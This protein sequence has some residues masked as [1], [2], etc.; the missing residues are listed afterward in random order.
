MAHFKE[1]RILSGSIMTGVKRWGIPLYSES[2]TLFGSA[3]ISLTSSGLARKRIVAINEFKRTDFPDPVVPAIKTWGILEISATIM[4]P[5]TSKP[6]PTAIFCLFVRNT[7]LESVLFKVTISGEILGISI[8]TKDFP[9]IGASIL[10]LP[11][12]VA[13]ARAR[14]F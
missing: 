2:S 1:D 3:R 9:G 13:N 11:V 14:S 10:T 12:V 8:P 7:S 5:E 4:F 6:R